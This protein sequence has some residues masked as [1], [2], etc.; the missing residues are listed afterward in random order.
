M[1]EYLLYTPKVKKKS[2][3]E[4]S[5]VVEGREYLRLYIVLHRFPCVLAGQMPCI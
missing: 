4:K 2:Q 3:R 1:T 5:V